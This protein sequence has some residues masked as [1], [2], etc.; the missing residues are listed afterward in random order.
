MNHT[1]PKKKRGSNTKI[2]GGARELKI[3]PLNL[4]QSSSFAERKVPLE[5]KKK[6]KG[7]TGFKNRKS[8]NRVQNGRVIKV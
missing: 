6:K 1:P 7:T 4:A 5:K 2:A 3:G 8:E